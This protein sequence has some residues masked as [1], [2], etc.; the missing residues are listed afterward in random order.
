TGPLT[1]TLSLRSCVARQEPI[2][3]GPYRSFRERSLA[4][5]V[6]PVTWRPPTFVGNSGIERF[7]GLFGFALRFFVSSFLRCCV[8]YRSS[9]WHR[10]HTPRPVR[11]SS[12]SERGQ[13]SI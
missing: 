11:R 9:L 10:R 7:N 3:P 6:D 5:S 13:Q 8:D 2:S 4:G 1:P 12:L